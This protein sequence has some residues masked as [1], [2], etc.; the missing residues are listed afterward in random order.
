MQSHRITGAVLVP[1]D[2]GK[3][4]HCYG[5]YQGPQL[6]V[7]VAPQDVRTYFPG[8][9]GKRASLDSARCTN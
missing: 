2:V 1:V 9:R 8:G 7:V 5:A 3:N 4:L 6:R